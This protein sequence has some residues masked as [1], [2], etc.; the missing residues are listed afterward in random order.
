MKQARSIQFALCVLSTI[1]LCT[2]RDARAQADAAGS[3][4][5]INIRARTIDG[6]IPTNVAVRISPFLTQNNTNWPPSPVVVGSNG[7][8]VATNVS[9]GAWEVNLECF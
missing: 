4:A 2:L 3:G 1:L 7:D 6:L 9:P 8:W 5:T